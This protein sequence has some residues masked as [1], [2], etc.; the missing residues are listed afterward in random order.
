MGRRIYDSDDNFVWKYTFARQSSEMNKYAEQ[1]GIGDYQEVREYHWY[2]DKKDLPALE[3]LLKDLSNGK[4]REKLNIIGMKAIHSYIKKQSDEWKK[5]FKEDIEKV[6]KYK[7]ENDFQFYG[8]SNKGQDF[9][10][11]NIF[12]NAIEQ[13]IKCSFDFY[14][15]T[16]TF[17]KH[18][19]ES[20]KDFFNFIDE[21]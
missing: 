10:I 12:A 11:Y 1:F 4:A 15:M 17:I 18:I 14:A 2:V 9:E 21:L 3:K 5:I 19:K 13:Y 7:S 20:K 6:K 16:E 8:S